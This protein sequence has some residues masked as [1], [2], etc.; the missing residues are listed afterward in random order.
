M[1]PVIVEKITV[2]LDIFEFFG[3]LAMSAPNWPSQ[4]WFPWAAVVLNILACV[5]LFRIMFAREHRELTLS[6]RVANNERQ[7]LDAKLEKYNE[8]LER[9]FSYVTIAH[10]IDALRDFEMRLFQH[11]NHI[12][13]ITRKGDLAFRDARMS[14]LE[15]KISSNSGFVAIARSDLEKVSGWTDEEK[16]IVDFSKVESEVLDEKFVNWNARVNHLMRVVSRRRLELSGLARDGRK[17]LIGDT[18]GA[19]SENRPKRQD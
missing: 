8:N 12:Y 9:V 2:P 19:E 6:D 18:E 15:A 13:N 4:T 7:M 17:N 14:D 5:F 11:R 16:I 3:W 1:V 10:E